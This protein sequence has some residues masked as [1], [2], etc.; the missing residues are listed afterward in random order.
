MRIILILL[1]STYKMNCIKQ[2]CI[3]EQYLSPWNN[4]SPM[5]T[6][7]RKSVGKYANDFKTI[8]KIL[9]ALAVI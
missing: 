8:R 6:D 4:N 9:S 1:I 5:F 7:L 3:N 2:H